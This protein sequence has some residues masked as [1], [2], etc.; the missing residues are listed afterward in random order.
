MLTIQNKTVLDAIKT[1]YTSSEVAEIGHLLEKRG[2]FHFP[3]LANGLFPAAD[4]A[5]RT[6]DVSKSGYNNIWVRDNIHIA[7]AHQVNGKSRAATKV[8]QTLATFFK[9]HRG[10]FRDII[11]GEANPNIPR[12]RPHV[13][14]D[15]NTLEELGEKWAHVQ[16][17]ALGYFLWLYCKLARAHEVEPLA[18]DMELLATFVDY[19]EAIE[20]WHDEDSGHWEEER[21]IEASSIGVV[22]GALIELKK[23]IEEDAAICTSSAFRGDIPG[24]LARLI[25]SGTSALN[26]I[27]PYECRERRNERKYDAAL[28]FL[29]YPIGI[30]TG[31]VAGE[32]VRNVREHLQ[33]EHGIRRY[34]GDSYWCGDYKKKLG[35]EKRTIDFSDDMAARDRFLKEGEEAQWCIFDPVISAIY[36][37]RFR[38]TWRR[39]DLDQQ[40]H[41]FNRAL[42]QLTGEESGFGGF[43]CPEA[44][45]LEDGRYVPNDHTPLLWT[46][47]NLWVAL[48]ILS[49][50]LELLSK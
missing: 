1:H 4:V 22:T 28:L 47:A 49:E 18:D 14:F 45:Y 16:N 5:K 23:L 8:V 10:R 30:I 3:A 24:K 31:E 50:N 11:R 15:G 27:L 36:G 9:K 35:A 37:E 46:Q 26:S 32:V 38:N 19:F 34:L 25:T 43:K 20:F 21:K 42:G 48:K 40:I 13:K 2:V 7:Y 33:G 17:D 39:E 44:Y 29:I 41:Y 12:N 6:G